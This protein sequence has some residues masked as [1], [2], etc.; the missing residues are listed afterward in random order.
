MEM[1]GQYSLG[2]MYV[3]GHGILKNQTQA[4]VWWFMSAVQGEK[5]ALENLHTLSKSM[6]EEQIAQAQALATKCWESQFQ[7]CD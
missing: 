1:Q 6:T 4:F 2:L 5:Q 7:D 3:K